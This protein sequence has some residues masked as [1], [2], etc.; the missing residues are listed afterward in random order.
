MLRVVSNVNQ[1]FKSSLC[2]KGYYSLVNLEVVSIPKCPDRTTSSDYLR[3][4]LVCL[5]T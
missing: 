4:V 2:K 3:T 5:F 1:A